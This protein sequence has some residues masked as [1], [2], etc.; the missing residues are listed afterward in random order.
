MFITQ[1]KVK[2]AIALLGGR[3]V[4][5]TYGFIKALGRRQIGAGQEVLRENGFPGQ[6]RLVQAAIAADAQVIQAIT[7][8]SWIKIHGN[9][10]LEKWVKQNNYM[11]LC[12][13][14]NFYK[15][16]IFS[17]TLINLCKIRFPY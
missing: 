13:I 1:R 12:Q 11:E 16:L 7:D 6:V 10:A 5:V 8:V 2:M 15:N 3:K 17:R 9:I 4:G 14:L